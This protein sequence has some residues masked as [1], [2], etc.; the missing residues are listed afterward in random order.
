MSVVTNAALIVFTAKSMK[1][2]LPE[3]VVIHPAIAFL[4]FEHLL[5]A[6]RS[7]IKIVLNNVPGRTHRIIARQ[8]YLVA[9]WF[10]IGWKSQFRADPSAKDLSD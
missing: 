3:D 6:V 5:F 8:E 4:F 2:V 7:F 1:E 9:R 10:N